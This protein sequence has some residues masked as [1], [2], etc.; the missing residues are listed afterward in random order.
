MAYTPMVSVNGGGTK[1]PTTKFGNVR[2]VGSCCIRKGK[3]PTAHCC[4]S[5]ASAAGVLVSSV[6]L[7]GKVVHCCC[8]AY[9][10]K[11]P[12]SRCGGSSRSCR[13]PMSMRIICAV[14]CWRIGRCQ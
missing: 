3:R 12:I 2:G 9:G 11:Q 7:N 4:S 5:M 10:L 13:S 6:P 8:V 14:C 1:T